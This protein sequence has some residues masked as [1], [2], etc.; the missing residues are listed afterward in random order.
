M[1][2]SPK[3]A[4]EFRP[5]RPGG[6]RRKR[7]LAKEFAPDWRTDGTI[8]AYLFAIDRSRCFNA[9]AVGGSQNW[10]GASVRRIR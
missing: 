9:D 7:V 6:V 4:A 5:E 2:H 3:S 8:A 1:V 10:D